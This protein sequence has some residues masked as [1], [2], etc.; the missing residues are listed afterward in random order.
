MTGPISI[1]IGAMSRLSTFAGGIR[2]TLGVEYTAPVDDEVRERTN[3][4]FKD[5]THRKEGQ[6]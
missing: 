6:G 5:L 4:N 3:S 2:G 1:G